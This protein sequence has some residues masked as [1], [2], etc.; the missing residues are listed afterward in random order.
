MQ[1]ANQDAFARGTGNWS[2]KDARTLYRDA[3]RTNRQKSWADLFR[4]LGQLMHLVADASVPEHVRDDMHP[5]GPVFGNYEYWVEAQHGRPGS[6]LEEAFVRG[7][8][9]RPIGFDPIILG[10]LTGDKIATVPIAWL[11]DTDSYIGQDPNVTLSPAIGIA[12]F[13]NANFFS[14]DTAP[15]S[16]YRFPDIRRLVPSTL[17]APRTGR[18]RAY[19]K[20]GGGDGLP[21]NPV[22]A[23]CVLEEA[24]RSQGMPVPTVKCVDE[25]VW[26]QTAKAM[27]PRA[28]GY[29]AGLL[30]YF[31]RG[32][33]AARVQ[34]AKTNAGL[35]ATVRIANLTPNEAMDG[36]FAI[37]YDAPDGTRTQLAGSVQR[38]TL[39]PNVESDS[40][41]VALPSTVPVSPW[42]LVFSGKLGLEE[43]A[44][45]ASSIRF[46]YLGFFAYT[47]VEYSN[48]GFFEYLQPFFDL[49]GYGQTSFLATYRNIKRGAANSPFGAGFTVTT[50]S[51]DYVLYRDPDPTQPPT[52]AVTPHPT[53][54][55]CRGE[56]MIQYGSQ[57]PRHTLLYVLPA[58]AQLVELEPPRDLATLFSYSPLNPPRVRRPLTDVI[59][60]DSPTTVV[61]I[62]GVRFLGLQLTTLPKDP[63]QLPPP[64]PAYAYPLHE[65][66]AGC[67]VWTNLAFP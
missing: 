10:R 53:F 25:N 60:T 38:L 39:A 48:G 15:S 17:P 14:E 43:G 63:G 44:V 56:D 66:T 21:V 29:S 6:P 26:A 37:Y 20:K 32:R 40:F 11:I 59:S 28:V 34:V 23:E 13:A 52:I 49:S 4:A 31:F 33:L 47:R 46:S 42:L 67:G 18:T 36:D 22:L 16:D 35:T 55:V 3:L 12:E 62:S 9:S 27:L 51:S 65:I 58:G 61:D 24:A 8:L 64:E 41:T 57:N 7:L 19:Y 5:L 1:T 54:S 2:W 45:A 50:G 30:D